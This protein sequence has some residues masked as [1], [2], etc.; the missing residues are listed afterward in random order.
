MTLKFNKCSKHIRILFILVM[1]NTINYSNFVPNYNND[2]RFKIA[3]IAKSVSNRTV[4]P[5]EIAQ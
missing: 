1:I 5:G 3:I 4:I 2:H